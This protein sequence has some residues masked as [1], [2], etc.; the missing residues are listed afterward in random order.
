MQKILHEMQKILSEGQFSV[1]CAPKEPFSVSSDSLTEGLPALSHQ[2]NNAQ[3]Q[4]RCVNWKSTALDQNR[5]QLIEKIQNL[6]PLTLL[7]VKYFGFNQLGSCTCT[8]S[9]LSW[10]VRFRVKCKRSATAAQ[11]S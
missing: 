7:N 10:P 2:Q 9:A 4:G 5:L 8:T 1:A 6:L 3:V 11:A